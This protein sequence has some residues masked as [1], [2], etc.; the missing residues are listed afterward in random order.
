MFKSRMHELKRIGQHYIITPEKLITFLSCGGYA[1]SFPPTALFMLYFPD[2]KQQY[3]VHCHKH[4]FEC[5]N[6]CWL[7]H[8]I[9]KHSMTTQ[10]AW[11]RN[12]IIVDVQ[13]YTEG[14]MD[15]GEEKRE[16]RGGEEGSGHSDQK[17]ELCNSFSKALTLTNPVTLSL[18][19]LRNYNSHMQMY[20]AV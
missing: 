10:F 6:C 12:A 14:E 1:F 13:M 20:K 3:T 11:S 19:H 9:E 5:H 4:V 15:G 17:E 7:R 16:G 18:K 8:Y 2:T